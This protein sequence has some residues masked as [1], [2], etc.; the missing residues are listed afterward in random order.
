M[1]DVKKKV[2]IVLGALV[3]VAPL[4]AIEVPVYVSAPAAIA[5]LVAA[6]YHPAPEK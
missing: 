2:G 4:L 6:Y 5:A 3:A 1:S